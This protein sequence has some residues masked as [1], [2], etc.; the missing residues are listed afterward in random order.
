MCLGGVLRSRLLHDKKRP[1]HFF[2]VDFVILILPELKKV[3]IIALSIFHLFKRADSRGIY[4]FFLW[5]GYARVK[6]Y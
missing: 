3:H 1:V 6:H 4:V 5:K 2:A